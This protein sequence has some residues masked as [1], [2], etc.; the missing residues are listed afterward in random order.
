MTTANYRFLF[1]S[2]ARIAFVAAITCCSVASAET[3]LNQLTQSEQKSGWQLLFDGKTTDGWRNYKK[4]SV[5]DGWKVTDGALV[6]AE[7]GAG[8][9]ITQDKF[10]SFELSLEYKIGEA[11]N[12]GVMFHVAET[13]GPPYVT[14]PEIQVQ[15][16]V[17]GHDPQKAGWLYQLYG[18][19]APNWAKDKSVVDT[20]RPAGQWNQLYI[21][22]AKEDCEVCMNGVRYYKFNIK[23]DDWKK[24]IAASKFANMP[25]F[26]MLGEG[27]ICLQDHND[28]V[29]FRNIKVRRIAEDGSVPQP[30]DAKLGMSSVLAFPNLKWAQWEPVD[31]S[32]KIRDLRLMEL[33]FAKGEPNRLYVASQYGAI[34]SF[35]NQPDVAESTLVLDLR[36]KV[37]DWKKPGA[38]EEGLLGL[39]MHP[40][41]KSNGQFYV[42]YTHPSELKSVLS[43]FT[44]ARDGSHVADPQSET[45]L[46]E[47]EQP[48]MN[49]NGGSIEFG[50]DGYLYVALGDGGDRNDPFANGQNRSTLLGSILR[51]DV[52]HPAKGK[53]YGIPADNPFVN[54]EG[55]LPE[56]YA[57]GLRNPWRIAFD[58]QTGD[59]WAG[60]VGQ[61]LWEEVDLIKKGGNYGWSTRE[62][63][64]AFGNREQSADVSEPIEPVWEYDHQIG[65]S[66]TGGRVYRSDRLAELAGKYLYADYVTGTV[67][68]LTY[69]ASTGTTTRNEQILPNSVPVLAFGQDASG[70]V[71]ILTN[72][73]RGECIYRFEAADSGGSQ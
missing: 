11:G 14:G 37:K 18:P 72:S 42:Y 54:V 53:N 33:T 1:F 29:A 66:I 22:V 64:H 68:A 38:N 20:T 3:P 47:I 10:A 49:H 58:P 13:D 51:L 36:G 46:M 57:Y 71:Y 61:E 55:A 21:R 48:F 19:S 28:E 2:S 32:G 7:K 26:G 27:Y 35:E 39:A 70:E 6:R 50:P 60:D 30:I 65:K 52:D 56:T 8:D 15:D 12:S 69:D 16:N 40:E 31:D 24:K 5:S 4:Q 41:F 59:L 73:T 9:L 63:T 25:N 45:I 62:G 44:V 17:A 43:R 67:W 34:W 23:N